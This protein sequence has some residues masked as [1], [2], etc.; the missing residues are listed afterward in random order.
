MSVS[1][2]KVAYYG[3]DFTGATDTLA[4]AA[5]AGLRSLLFLGLPTDAQLQ[6][7]GPLDC[8]GIA[9]AARAM[10]PDEMRAELE[11][12]GRLFARLGAPVMHYKT[13]ST[14][15]SAPQVGSIGAAIRILQP[16]AG[17]AFVP[18]VGGQPNLRRYCVFGNLFAGAGPAVHRL[19]RHPTMS[20]HPVTPM[21]EAD[22]RRHLAA[23]GL[24]QVAAIAYPDY[25]Q[26]DAALDAQL[27]TLLA[28]KPDA[29]LLDVAHA[30][31]LATVGRLI[32]QR[33]QQQNLLAA[34]PSSVVQALAAHWQAG[35]EAAPPRVDAASGPV[36]VLAGSLS[37]V[38]AR[39]V[40]AA[41]AYRQ[42]ALNAA[43]LTGD[44]DYAQQMAA[45]I[46]AL[47]AQGRHVLACTSADGASNATTD[48]RALAQ[49]CGDLL[50]RVLKAVPLRRL[51]IAG[52][53]TSS[54]AVQALDAWGLSYA[55]QLAP[56]VALCRL[57]SDQATLDGM[58][59][60]LKGGQ[61]GGEDLFETL[62][63]GTN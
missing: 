46:A 60:M 9:G 25:E 36:L 16:H 26:D 57:H 19:D 43:R 18:I 2:L 54:H 52:G 55:A 30:G 7:A 24:A 49:A 59:I 22:L 3:D 42:V 34:G 13:C 17:N 53:D 38:T 21:H 33:A 12:V 4:T 32:W 15:D 23:Q 44:A 14:F 37:P 48:G 31:H 62:L 10:N 29:V 45:Q 6:R 35:D 5:R 61:M 11:P 47:L 41:S 58:E 20:R 63:H 39:Q 40:Q 27:D 1:S 51:G 56:G 8:L 50:A 28:G